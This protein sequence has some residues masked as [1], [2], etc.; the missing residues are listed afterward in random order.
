MKTVM[1]HGMTL[2]AFV[3]SLGCADRSVAGHGCHRPLCRYPK[4]A[5][6]TGASDINDVASLRCA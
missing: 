5:R 2:A 1:A 4:V 3:P 6:C